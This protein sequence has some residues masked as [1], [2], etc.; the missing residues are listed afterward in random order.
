MTDRVS[1]LYVILEQDIREDDVEELVQAIRLLRGVLTVETHVADFEEA[2]AQA[3]V[4]S[5]LIREL[6]DALNKKR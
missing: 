1:G 5:E 4:R 2:I 3:R 6:W